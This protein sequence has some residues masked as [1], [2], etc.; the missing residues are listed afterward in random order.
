ME[1]KILFL[2]IAIAALY[3]LFSKAGQDLIKNMVGSG[4]GP[5]DGAAGIAAAKDAVAV[6]PANPINNTKM[7]GEILTP[8]MISNA[9]MG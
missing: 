6:D 3:L 2:I 1:T 4:G 5:I 8:S 9:L 7:S